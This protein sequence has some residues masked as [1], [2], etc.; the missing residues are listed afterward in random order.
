MD[1]CCTISLYC[2]KNGE[3]DGKKRSCRE[4]M[5]QHKAR[6]RERNQDPGGAVHQD[7]P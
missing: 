6:R 2:L 1:Y 4:K 3:F 7:Q 5:E